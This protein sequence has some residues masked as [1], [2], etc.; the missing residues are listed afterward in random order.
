MSAFEASKPTVVINAA[1]YT[2]VERAEAEPD[3]AYR[4]NREGPKVLAEVSAAR[5]VPL[6]HVSTDFVFDGRNAGPYSEHHKVGPL[7]VYGLS[8]ESGET[9]VRNLQPRHIIVR[10]GWV[11]GRFGRNFLKT[12]VDLSAKRDQLSI[13]ADQVGTPTAADDLAQ[14]LMAAANRASDGDVQWGTYHFGGSAP[15]SWY[16]LA[17]GIICAQREVTGRGP[18]VSPISAD[19]YPSLVRRPRNSQLNSDRFA[20]HFGVRAGA[21]QQRVPEIVKSIVQ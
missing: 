3:A 4:V 12:I 15:G 1:A 7:C 9:A 16:D 5:G 13:V 19:E 17:K 6:I 21:W 2:N 8:K 11:Y 10:T 20:T 18:I 14:A